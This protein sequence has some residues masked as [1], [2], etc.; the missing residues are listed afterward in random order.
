M[1]TRR[2]HPSR[3]E[4]LRGAKP[5]GAEP[6][7]SRTNSFVRFQSVGLVAIQ[8]LP[9]SIILGEQQQ[10]RFA[11][12]NTPML[13][14]EGRLIKVKRLWERCRPI[15]EVLLRFQPALSRTPARKN[16]CGSTASPSI[17]VS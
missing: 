3:A 9:A 17:L 7:M 16:F 6:G 12:W 4:P 2:T 14:R 1:K 5:G 13:V 8:G 15:E 11:A 10:C